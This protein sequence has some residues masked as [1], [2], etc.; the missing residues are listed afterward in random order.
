MVSTSDCEEENGKFELTFFGETY[1]W[2][3]AST[4]ERDN[5]LSFRAL[6]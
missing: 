2:G 1:I 4:S 3:G 5:P 6:N